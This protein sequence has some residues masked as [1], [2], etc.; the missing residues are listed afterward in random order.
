VCPHPPAVLVDRPTQ[1]VC[2]KDD[3]GRHLHCVI[4]GATEWMELTE[5]QIVERVCADLVACFGTVAQQKPLSARAIKERRATFVPSPSSYRARPS[6]EPVAVGGVLLAG[7]YTQ[8]GWPAT[9]ES[10]VRSGAMAA[11]VAMGRAPDAFLEPA[12]GR[13]LLTRFLP[14]FLQSDSH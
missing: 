12:L 5:A 2:R 11:A 13:P 14:P 4:A 8:T 1:W 7:D 10:A 9:M 3:A 6:V